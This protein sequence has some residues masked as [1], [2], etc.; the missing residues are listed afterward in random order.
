VTLAND[1]VLSALNRHFV[2]GFKNITGEPYAGKSG[3]HDPDSPAVLTTNGAGPH[4]VQ[5]FFLDADGTVL[6]CL[7]GYWCP[8]DFLAEMQFALALDKVYR[9]PN[10]SAD[11]KKKA[12]HDANLRAIATISSAMH[13]RSRLQGFDAKAE[14]KKANSDF[15][16][17]PGDYHPALYTVGK[18]KLPK[19]AD[20]KTVDQVV[21]ERMAKRPFVPYDQF[22]VEAFSDYGKM[23]YDRH[24]N[25]PPKT[26]RRN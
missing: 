3:K 10:L 16:Y 1:Q 20:L 4:N 26:A 2:C 18:G 25:E 6:H 14:R 22:D 9:N 13:Q 12:A 8:A 23:R 7:P 11:A 17:K 24:E 15:T 21:H 5:L 19:N